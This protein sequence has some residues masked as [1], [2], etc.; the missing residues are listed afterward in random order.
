MDTAERRDRSVDTIEAS[1]QQAEHRKEGK[2]FVFLIKIKILKV[3]QQTFS[4]TFLECSDSGK[5]IL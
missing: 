1:F 2:E 4:L 5:H 3:G